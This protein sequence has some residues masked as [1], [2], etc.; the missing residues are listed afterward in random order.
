M[1]I[2]GLTADEVAARDAKVRAEQEIAE[3]TVYLSSTDWYATRLAETGKAIPTGVI[4]KRQAARNRIS[5]L[6]G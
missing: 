6:R 2:K 5:E 3:L 1:K 4:E